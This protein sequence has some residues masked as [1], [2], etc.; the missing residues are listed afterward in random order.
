MG[1]IYFRP[2]HNLYYAKCALFSLK[3][4][5]VSKRERAN[6]RKRKGVNPPYLVVDLGD[7]FDVF[8]V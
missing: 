3:L 5:R 1:A 4:E 2:A 8:N 6:E 7:K